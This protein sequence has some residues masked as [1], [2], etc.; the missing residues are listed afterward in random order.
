VGLSDPDGIVAWL[1]REGHGDTPEG[2]DWMLAVSDASLDGEEDRS[3]RAICRRCGLIRRKPLSLIAE[4]FIDLGGPC[5]QSSAYWMALQQ[6]RA[7]ARK[8]R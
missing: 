4:I 2:H 8:R 3:V 7:G 6:Q 1:R 5:P